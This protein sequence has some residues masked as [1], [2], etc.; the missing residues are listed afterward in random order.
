MKQQPAIERRKA[1]GRDRALEPATE[2]KRQSRLNLGSMMRELVLV[3]D[4][5]EA[6]AKRFRAYLEKLSFPAESLHINLEIRLQGSALRFEYS[7]N[8]RKQFCFDVLSALDSEV[9]DRFVAQAFPAQLLYKA[10]QLLDG[11]PSAIVLTPYSFPMSERPLRKGSYDL[12]P[13]RSFYP[14]LQRAWKLGKQAFNKSKTFPNWRDT[15][16]SVVRQELSS[17]PINRLDPDPKTLDRLVERL[18]TTNAALSDNQIAD[19]KDRCDRGKTATPHELALDHA[20]HLCGVP[21][22]RYGLRHLENQIYS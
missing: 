15:V 20:A 22:Y 19:L 12:T 6:Q 7:V 17:A 9:R 1:Q 13:M 11:A 2:K 3:S 8:G 14:Y 5:K 4:A 18:G 21:L 10:C 16:K